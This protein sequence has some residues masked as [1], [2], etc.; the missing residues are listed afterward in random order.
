MKKFS[1][2]KNEAVIGLALSKLRNVRRDLLDF[3]DEQR[4]ISSGVDD[5][6]ASFVLNEKIIQ[7]LYEEKMELEK[8]KG[9]APTRPL[10]R[11]PSKWR[12]P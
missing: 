11:S 8:K 3:F 7:S 6:E 9:P 2:L 12:C 4:I 5:L 10:S 1:D